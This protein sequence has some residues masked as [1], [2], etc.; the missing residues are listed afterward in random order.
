[1]A[2]CCERVNEPSGYIK[3][4][5]FPDFAKGL[6]ASEKSTLSTQLDNF[7]RRAALVS[8]RVRFQAEDT[9]S[10]ATAALSDAL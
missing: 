9:V 1:M 4:G 6:T 8:S 5:G 10:V 3:C 7:R 2:E